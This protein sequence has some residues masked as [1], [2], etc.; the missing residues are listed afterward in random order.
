[1]PDPLTCCCYSFFSLIPAAIGYK[2][3]RSGPFVLPFAETSREFKWQ[4]D[5]VDVHRHRLA[6]KPFLSI[7]YK[8]EEKELNK[9]LALFH[10]YQDKEL[11]SA[12]KITHKL[13]IAFSFLLFVFQLLRA[14]DVD[15][16][17]VRK[18]IELFAFL[19]VGSCLVGTA[20]NAFSRLSKFWHG[21]AGEAPDAP[22]EFS[23]FSPAADLESGNNPNNQ[24]QQELVFK[25]P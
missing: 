9:H 16:T 8:A 5:D 7:E 25:G 18:L 13:I 17:P 19:A 12:T 20:Q 24:P 3:Q 11:N 21:P 4:Q 22:M 1:M 15:G 2:R 6:Q 14:F 10:N 23:Q